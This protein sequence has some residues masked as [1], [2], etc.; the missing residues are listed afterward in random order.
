VTAQNMVDRDN[1]QRSSAIERISRQAGNADLLPYLE[2]VPPKDLQTLLLELF[3]RNAE[4]VTPAEVMSRY[5]ERNRYLGAGELDQR[6]LINFDSI[7]YSV[8]PDTYRGVEF[9][10]TGP[11]GTNAALTQLSQDMVPTTIRNSEVVSDPTVMLALEAARSRKDLLSVNK[12]DAT[13]INLCTS[14]RVLRLQPFDPKFGYMQH[15][16]VLA[17]TT[18]GHNDN[19]NRF[20]S[21]SAT[22][23]ISIFL[24]FIDGLNAN[25]YSIN[26]VVVYLSNIKIIENV[27]KSSH[28][29]PTNIRRNT[30]TVGFDPLKELGVG[31]PAVAEPDAVIDQELLTKYG[32]E[33]S[34]RFLKKTGETVL[35]PL[36]SNHPTVKFGFDVGRHAGIGYYPNFCFHIYGTNDDGLRLQLADGGL[37]DWT[38]LLL[39]N[40][41]ELFM[42][43]GFGSEL[44]NK[45][46]RKK[47]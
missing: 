45:M 30:Q 26:D 40:D 12:Q 5:E 28:S 37:T 8:V 42:A 31:L 24:N 36:L 35:Q 15:F 16:R 39:N 34:W 25:G 47:A 43:S 41:R 21:E 6:S 46:F 13:R 7:F 1:P 32:I 29:D 20:L 14:S 3:A 10:P 27:V 33:R 9:S 19:F 4:L 18:A 23:H 2:K 11:F 22:E 17:V 44:I 38:K